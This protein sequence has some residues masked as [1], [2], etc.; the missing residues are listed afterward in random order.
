M[1]RSDLAA[2][3][4]VIEQKLQQPAPDKQRSGG[5]ESNLQ[6]VLNFYT[7]LIAQNKGRKDGASDLSTGSPKL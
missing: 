5:D 3:L 4:R 2:L 6:A 1:P 7:D